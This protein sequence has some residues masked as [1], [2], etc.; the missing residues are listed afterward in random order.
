MT[1]A[2]LHRKFESFDV[3]KVAE[4]SLQQTKDHIADLNVEQMSKGLKSDGSYMP[5]YSPVSV[6]VFGKPEG[7][8]KL[9]DKGDFYQ[10]YRVTIENGNV[11][12]TSTDEKTG[13]LFK[14]FATKTSNI[15]GLNPQYRREYIN[16]FLK[17]NFRGNIKQQTGL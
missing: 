1:I 16:E 2:A 5:D 13:M 6:E 12:V 17:K 9:F 15:F 8:I 3:A 7:P 11:V 4:E 10:G 14:R